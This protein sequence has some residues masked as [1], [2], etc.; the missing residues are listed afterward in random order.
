MSLGQFK[1]SVVVVTGGGM[2]LGKAYCQAFAAEGAK[3]VCPDYNEEAAKQTAAEINAAGGTALAMKVDVTKG[4]QVEA[5]VSEI[6]A[7]FGKI[8]V[9]VNNVGYLKR[10][11][12]LQTPEDIWDKII[13]TN[14]KSAFLV[15]KAV[16]PYMIERKKGKIINL[17]SVVGLVAVA[18]PPYSAAKS[19]MMGLTRILALELAPY[20]INV[21]CLA[22][23]FI[24]TPGSSA[25]H[26]SPVGRRV[27]EAV[28]LGTGDTDCIVPVVLFL[29]SP[30]SDYITGQ[31]IVV[32][33]GF[34]AS[35]D[36][37]DEFRTLDVGK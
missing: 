6:I 23:G 13:D 4:D 28:P 34:T 29:S 22:P 32:D 19:G 35:H 1:D 30:G 9:L 11:P 20:K 37:G 33:G 12:L 16:A 15:S 3:V 14:L 17:S 5:M 24:R 26:N 27:N 7:K 2:G 8:D 18:S 25:V 21:N 10:L 36:F 31:T